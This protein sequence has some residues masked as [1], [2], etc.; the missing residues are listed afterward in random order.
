MPKPPDPEETEKTISDLKSK[1]LIVEGKNDEKALKSLGLNNIIKIDR[2]PL[3]QIAREVSGAEEIVILT[4]FD[5][6][7][8]ELAS[9]LSRLLIPRK[10]RI[11]Q[12]LRKKVMEFGKLEI[13]SLKEDDLNVKVGTSINKIRDKSKNKSERRSRKA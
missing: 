5:R 2:K 4:D 8:R 6:K 7:G 13:E 3:Y 1:L 9:R 11:N 12:R 10:I